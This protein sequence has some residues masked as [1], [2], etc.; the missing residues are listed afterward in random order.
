MKDYDKCQCGRKK[1]KVAKACRRCFYNPN[2]KTK[3][4]SQCKKQQPIAAFGIK[5]RYG[6]R[7]P[8]TACKTCEVQATS[9]WYQKR[10]ARETSQEATR[11]RI[12]QSCTSLKIPTTHRPVI[13]ALFET[14]TTCE[15]CGFPE[16][17][18][19]RLAIDH[20]HKTGVFRGLLCGM[21]NQMLG[22]Q[23]DNPQI[24]ERAAQ[25]LRDRSKGHAALR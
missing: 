16:T 15:I 18:K 20:C 1:R 4:C 7:Y 2:K 9:R 10:K 14:Q 11:R 6:K 19:P 24:F 17:K 3:Q 21:C 8:R 25:Y 12:L 23:E 5:T 13:L 22:A